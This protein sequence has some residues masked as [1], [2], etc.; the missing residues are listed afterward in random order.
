MSLEIPVPDLFP[1]PAG[2]A[3]AEQLALD[4]YQRFAAA[5]ATAEQAAA[6]AQAT[7]DAH[8][9]GLHKT[10]AALA[11]VN[12]D[13]RGLV[14][15]VD[16]ATET[17]RVLD[18]FSREWEALLTRH[19]VEVRDLTG[20]TFD[21]EV[22][23][24]VEDVRGAVPDAN[25][26]TVT[27]RETIVPLVLHRGQVIGRATVLKTVP[28]VVETVPSVEHLRPESSGREGEALAHPNACSGDPA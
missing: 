15:R 24:W 23:S 18:L 12:F 4:L 27:V 3:D 16:P 5:R 8:A 17:G 11:A 10:L 28:A 6:G 7:I 9:A 13:F 14:R 22:A 19:G 25:V 21:D 26:T 2:P 20:L 1:E